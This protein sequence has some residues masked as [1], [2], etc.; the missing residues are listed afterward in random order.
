MANSA[1][2]NLGDGPN[3]TVPLPRPFPL[4]LLKGRTVTG[5]LG[6]IDTGTGNNAAARPLS[7]QVWPRGTN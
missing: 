1:T 4:P 6:S 3:M 5:D 7:G 2:G